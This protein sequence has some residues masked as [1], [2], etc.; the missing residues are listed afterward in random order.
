MG[1][2]PLQL[3]RAVGSGNIASPRRDAPWTSGL[4][5]GRIVADIMV[6]NG[7]HGTGR[8]DDTRAKYGEDRSAPLNPARHHSGSRQQTG[9]SPSRLDRDNNRSCPARE[10]RVSGSRGRLRTRCW[11]KQR[12]RVVTG[13][14]YRDGPRVGACQGNG[15]L[16]VKR[17]VTPTN[18]SMDAMSRNHSRHKSPTGP[19][20]TRCRALRTGGRITSPIQAA[21]SRRARRPRHD[22]QAQNTGKTAAFARTD[23][24]LLDAAA[25]KPRCWCWRRPGVAIQVPRP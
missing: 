24:A 25:S 13:M 17:A 4:P 18:E 8:A 1:E 15:Y 6:A 3:N 2:R 14:R 11:R 21:T 22:R 9:A 12:K 16:C 5:S 19:A 23:L 10:H 7:L 20:G